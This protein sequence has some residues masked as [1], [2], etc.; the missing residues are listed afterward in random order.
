MNFSVRLM[1]NNDISE[2]AVI[3][4][5][6][7]PTMWPPIPFK[8]ELDNKLTEYFVINCKL[9]DEVVYPQINLNTSFIKKSLKKLQNL[10]SSKIS[11]PKDSIIV[12]YIG[13]W[14]SLDE[15]HITSIA[16][17]DEFRRMGLGEM[18]LIAAFQ[19]AFKK[20]MNSV[21][22][23]VRVTNEIAQN[24]YSK[25]DLIEVGRRKRYYSD[26]QED[27]IIMTADNIF[28]DNYYQE[29]QVKIQKY[30]DKHQNITL[31][32]DNVNKL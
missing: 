13:I 18:L 14:Y 7:F 32:E 3:E 12:G 23:E 20:K 22:L 10:F 29:I 15:S 16:T 4:R 31:L 6:A 24:L 2:V 26:N 25:Y 5:Q 19:R 27:A 8:R 11:V 30:L 28:A 17:R 21:T 9:D 1:K